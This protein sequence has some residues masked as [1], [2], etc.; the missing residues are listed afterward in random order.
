ML[1]L[2]KRLVLVLVI[3]ALPTQALAVLVTPICHQDISASPAPAHH[4][5]N[6]ESGQH[7]HPTPLSDHN[8]PLTMGDLGMDHCS[9]GCAFALPVTLSNAIF[10]SGSGHSSAAAV[11]FSGHIP[12]QPHRPPLA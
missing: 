7:D 11:R 3:A 5:A 1:A 8:H 10:A 4:H 2:M 12:E 9:S 6:A